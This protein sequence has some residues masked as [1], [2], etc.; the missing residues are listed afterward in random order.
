MLISSGFDESMIAV[1]KREKEKALATAKKLNGRIRHFI[2]VLQK[3][4]S[5][6]MQARE[7]IVKKLLELPI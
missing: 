6:N 3:N 4:P 2:S 5:L 1:R 7:E